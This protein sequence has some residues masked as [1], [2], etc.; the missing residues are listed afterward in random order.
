MPR[1]GYLLPTR[2]RVME[3]LPETAS[4]LTLAER[5]ES[6]GFDSVWAGDSLLAR[7]RHD[8]L[9]L[10][11]AVAARTR[12]VELGTAVLLPALRN[13]VVLAHQV[14]TLD[15]I[16]EGRLILGVGIAADVPA[17][18]AEFEAA[19]VP[20]DKRVGRLVEGLALAR[21]LWT[22]KPVD[23]EGR[24]KVKAAVLGPTPHRPGGPP[25][26]VAGAVAA[27][28]QRTGRLFDGWFPNSPGVSEY[29]TQWAEVTEAA[30]AAG[31]DP[32]TLTGAMYLTL[33]IDDD[34]TRADAKL[35]D[36]LEQYYGV[37]P[38]ATRKRQMSYAGPAAGAA[39]WLKAY[40]DAGASHLVLRFAGD[41]ERHLETVAGLRRDLGW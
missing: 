38:L 15:R 7:P 29:K 41:H 8:P 1:V 21:A 3:G 10:L 37:P 26:W 6:L 23:W 32:A 12:K 40:A 9:T 25:I 39:A 27:A 13:P 14:A 33:A 18:R 11:A 2:E 22:G 34:T 31:R 30:R 35:N 5:A 16:S 4:L 36:Y 19:G 17:I 24:W 20:F 28:R